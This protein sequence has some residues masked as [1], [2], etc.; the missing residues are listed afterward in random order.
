MAD[1][2]DDNKDKK[3]KKLTK[4]ELRKLKGGRFSTTT[5][6]GSCCTGTYTVAG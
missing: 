5:S 3:V 6:C 4:E 2:K 1:K